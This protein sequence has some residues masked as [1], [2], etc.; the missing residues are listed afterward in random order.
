MTAVELSKPPPSDKPSPVQ[1]PPVN[2]PGPRPPNK[3]DNPG[4]PGPIRHN[5]PEANRSGF[6]WSQYLDSPV[7]AS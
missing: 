3:P 5:D 2:P 7:R 6:E 4:Q 1:P